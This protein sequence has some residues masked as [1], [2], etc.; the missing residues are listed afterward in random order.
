MKYVFIF[1]ALFVA[2]NLIGTWYNAKTHRLT[3]L[4][5]VPHIDKWRGFPS[6]LNIWLGLGINKAIIGLALA[7]GFIKSKFQNY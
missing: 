4:D 2:Y 1:L 3:G 6:F 5:A 7:R